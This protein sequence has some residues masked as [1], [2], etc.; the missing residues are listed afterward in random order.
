MYVVLITDVSLSLILYNN[1]L[2]S[3]YDVN[4]KTYLVFSSEFRYYIERSEHQRLSNNL[5]LFHF[6]SG[7]HIA[8]STSMVHY[9]Y[10]LI[11][12]KNLTIYK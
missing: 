5:C 11:W 2:W 6:C 3:S 12:L 7:A 4:V 8:G 9:Y 1:C 10:L